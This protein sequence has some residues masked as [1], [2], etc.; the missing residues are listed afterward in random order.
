[1][2]CR[3]IRGE[4]TSSFKSPRLEEG[5]EKEVC[6][7]EKSEVLGLGCGGGKLRLGK[8]GKSGFTFPRASRYGIDNVSS[9][10]FD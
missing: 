3:V 9:T 1:M 10:E 6:V 8:N 4:T 2:K 5:I 7:T